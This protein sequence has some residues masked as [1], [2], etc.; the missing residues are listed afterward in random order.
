M[1]DNLFDSNVLKKC[2]LYDFNNFCVLE[3]IST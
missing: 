3:T 2:D 1:W